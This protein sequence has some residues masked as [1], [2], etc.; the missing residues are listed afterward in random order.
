MSTILQQAAAVAAA[1]S[2]P[3]T[4]LCHC[5]SHQQGNAVAGRTCLHFAAEHCEGLEELL[6][7]KDVAID[8]EV[9]D[10]NEETILH[11][12]A[13]AGCPMAAYALTKACPKLCLETNKDDKSPPDVAKEKNY[14][15][16]CL[17]YFMWL[18]KSAM[19]GASWASNSCKAHSCLAS[20]ISDVTLPGHHQHAA[21]RMQGTNLHYWYLCDCG[22]LD[23]RVRLCNSLSA[24]VERHVAGLLFRG[25]QP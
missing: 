12:A 17:T 19:Q 13:A 14:L 21:A 2:R 22:N 9:K 18:A 10:K 23:M 16:V 5:E 25:C 15:E 24:G 3:W 4:L 20:T 7:L 6:L 1:S 11:F 8:F